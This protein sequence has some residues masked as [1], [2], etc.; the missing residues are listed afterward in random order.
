LGR[1]VAIAFNFDMCTNQVQHLCGFGI[2]PLCPGGSFEQSGHC[3]H[4]EDA[5][6]RATA[7]SRLPRPERLIPQDVQRAG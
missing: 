1:T 3:A 2:Q 6:P 4:V 7:S 5:H